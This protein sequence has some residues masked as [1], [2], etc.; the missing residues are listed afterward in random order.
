MLFYLISVNI[1][2]IIS[3]ENDPDI[4]SWDFPN[5][6]INIWATFIFIHAIFTFNT[7]LCIN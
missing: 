4:S 2:G 1:F 5:T 3:N 7:I 6:V